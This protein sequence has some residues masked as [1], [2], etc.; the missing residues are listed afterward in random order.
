MTQGKHSSIPVQEALGDALDRRWMLC[1]L[2]LLERARGKQS[3][4]SQYIDVLPRTY[5]EFSHGNALAVSL[6][7]TAKQAVTPGTKSTRTHTSQ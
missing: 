5:S 7:S 6:L 4:W 2:L 3:F 1:L